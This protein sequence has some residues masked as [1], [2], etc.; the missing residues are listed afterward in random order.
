MLF[1]IS[2]WGAVI[3]VQRL[4]DNTAARL[5]RKLFAESEDLQ[6]EWQQ[7]LAKNKPTGAQELYLV[8]QAYE[9]WVSACENTKS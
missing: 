7:Q 5:E 3:M 9:K 6:K 8:H 2:L 1:S 4:H